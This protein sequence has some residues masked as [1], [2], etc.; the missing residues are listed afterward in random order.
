MDLNVTNHVNVVKVMDLADGH[1]S[2]ATNLPEILELNVGGYHFTTTLSTLQKYPGSMLSAMFSGRHSVAMD[3]NGSYFIDRDGS[4]FHHVLNF[5]RQSEMPPL[6]ECIKVYHEAQF[7]NVHPFIEALELLKPIAG[8]KIRRTFLSHV[9]HYDENL[10]ILLEKAQVLASTQPDRVSR[11]RVCI[12]KE[13][14]ASTPY[15]NSIPPLVPGEWNPFKYRQSH[16]CDV[17]VIFGPWNATPDVY[18]LL[19]CIKH[20]LSMKGYDVESQCIG[21]CDKLVIDQYFCKRPIYEL[22]F[23]WW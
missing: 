14:A 5:L 12:Y 8:E 22:R 17:C 6:S 15:E 11:L 2:S 3:K 20:D 9:P 10:H 23:K 16:K 13:E 4:N 18:D 1:S 7:Y 19:D 21:V